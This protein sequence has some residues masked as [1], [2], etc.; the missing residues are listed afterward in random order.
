MTFAEQ[1][2]HFQAECGKGGETSAKAN[3]EHQ[4]RFI[5]EPGALNRE[6]DDDANEQTPKNIYKKRP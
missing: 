6:P 4:R 3:T 5:G 2:M 1:G